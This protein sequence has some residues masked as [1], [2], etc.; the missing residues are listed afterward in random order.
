MNNNT[1][2]T[3]NTVDPAS[4]AYQLALIETAKQVHPEYLL[5]I[6]EEEKFKLMVGIRAELKQLDLAPEVEDTMLTISIGNKSF[7]WLMTAVEY[8]ALDELCSAVVDD[9]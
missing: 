9:I 7:S 6:I 1:N 8:N 4:K 3:S 5:N 2:K